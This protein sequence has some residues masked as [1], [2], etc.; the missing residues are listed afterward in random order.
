MVATGSLDGRVAVITGSTRSIG[1]AIA[2][3]FLAD[4]ATVVVSGR[5]EIKGKQAL[6]EMNAG[7]RAVFHPCDAGRQ[8]DIEALA[9]F[10]AE[11]FGL[12]RHLGQQRRMAAP[13][14]PR[15]TSSATR[16]GT[17]PST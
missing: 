4:G 15:S 14:S 2:E 11:R 1:R 3:A 9:D 10:A 13:A 5:S 12:L 7:D 17:P 16:R 6:E 8:E